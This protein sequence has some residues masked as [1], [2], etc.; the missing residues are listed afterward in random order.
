MNAAADALSRYDEQ[1]AANQIRASLLSRPEFCLFDAFRQEAA[2]LLEIAMKLQEI[3]IGLTDGAWMEADGFALHQGR[4]FVPSSSS[5]WPQLLDHAHGVGHEG[6]QKTLVRLRASLYCPKASRLI[7]DFVC[8][9]LVYQRNK[10]K[11][12][13]PAGFLQHLKVPSS[14]WSDIAMDFV[15]RFPRVGGTCNTLKIPFNKVSK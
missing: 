12:L 9:C 14:V 4:I 10:M 15:E 7:Q 2:T 5:L 1:E 11:H 6:I 8:G 3:C 13:H